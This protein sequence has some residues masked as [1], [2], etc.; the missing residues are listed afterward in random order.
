MMLQLNFCDLSLLI[1]NYG[2]I[3][4][5]RFF[6]N[7]DGMLCSKKKFNKTGFYIELS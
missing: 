5:E 6:W 1:S 4:Y 3:D 7:I 2:D